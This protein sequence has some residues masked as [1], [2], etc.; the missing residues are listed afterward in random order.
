ME[1]VGDGMLAMGELTEAVER[2]DL[3]AAITA[4]GTVNERTA[5]LYEKAPQIKEAVDSYLLA[6]QQCRELSTQGAA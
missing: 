1:I 4:S 3:E 2:D 5:D 6:S